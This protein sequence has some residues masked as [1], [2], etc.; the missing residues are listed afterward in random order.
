MH[1]PSGAAPP[2]TDQDTAAFLFFFF[3]F[4][5]KLTP[6]ELFA[7]VEGNGTEGWCD[8]ARRFSCALNALHEHAGGMQGRVH[9]RARVRSEAETFLVCAGLQGS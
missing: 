4:I 2:L 9:E 5:F 7:C 3:N 8:P 6:R 1:S